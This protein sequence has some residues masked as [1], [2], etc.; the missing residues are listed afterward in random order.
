MAKRRRRAMAAKGTLHVKT[1]PRAV[2]NGGKSR[3]TATLIDEHGKL[4]PGQEIVFNRKKDGADI[5]IGK[6][7]TAVADG[8]AT[9]DFDPITEPSVAKGNEVIVWATSDALRSDDVKI[10]L[11]ETQAEADFDDKLKQ[12]AVVQQEQQEQERRTAAKASEVQNLKQQIDS[13]VKTPASPPEIGDTK[14]AYEKAFNGFKT[15]LADANGKLTEIETLISAQIDKPKR[16]GIVAQVNQID[17]DIKALTTRIGQLDTEVTTLKA[18]VTTATE[19]LKQKREEWE[20]FKGTRVAINRK[21]KECKDENDD[22]LA[23]VKEGVNKNDKVALGQQYLKLLETRGK[24]GEIN[25]LA[26][27]PAALEKNL[28]AAWQQIIAKKQ[29]LAK[30]EYELEQKENEKNQE[31]EKLAN[32]QKGREEEI[33]TIID[34]LVK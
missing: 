5:V 8:A 4:V 17:V 30:A 20:S 23:A 22:L 27:E 16:D 12:L 26:V 6:A 18:R 14:T 1:E 32:R 24:V 10:G 34:K 29:E 15:G 25:R 28:A 2:M 13:L 3:L 7:K 31:N 33:K 11:F 21:L 9:V 19:Q